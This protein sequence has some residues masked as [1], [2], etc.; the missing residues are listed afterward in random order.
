MNC[1]LKEKTVFIGIVGWTYIHIKIDP[2]ITI[3]ELTPDEAKQLIADENLK[4]VVSNSFGKVYDDGKF[5][6]YVNEH[7]KIKETLTSLIS[8]IE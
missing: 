7:P 1:L 6:D 5:K 4:L 2:G 8:K 3:N